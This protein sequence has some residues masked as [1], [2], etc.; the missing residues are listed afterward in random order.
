MRV[1]AIEQQATRTRKRVVVKKR[2]A[3]KAH[4]DLQLAG[5]RS[6]AT[7]AGFLQL[8]R[9]LRARDVIDEGSIDRIREAMLS[10][11]LENLPRSLVGDA[12]YEDHLRKRLSSLLAQTDGSPR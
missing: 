1:V 12:N 10:E 3:Q 8:T 6:L 5:F 11:L 7:A 4:L 2:E 9:E